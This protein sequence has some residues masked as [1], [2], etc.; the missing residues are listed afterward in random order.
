MAEAVAMALADRIGKHE[1]HTLIE[2]ACRR[3]VVDGAP[4]RDVLAHDPAVTAQLSAELLDR[5]F[6]PEA[7]LGMA[8]RFV[9]RVLAGRSPRS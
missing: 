8:E 9:Q 7:Y 2:A 1:A 6:A 4:L 3:A 5:L